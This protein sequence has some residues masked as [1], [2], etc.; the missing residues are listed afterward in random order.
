MM[1]NI[2][3]RRVWIWISL[4]A[5]SGG[6]SLIL[7]ITGV[8][9]KAAESISIVKSSFRA[10]MAVP[11]FRRLSHHNSR[12]QVNRFKLLNSYLGQ[13][14]EAHEATLGNWKIQWWTIAFSHWI[15]NTLKEAI[16]MSSYKEA[17]IQLGPSASHHNKCQLERY[18]YHRDCTNK[19]TYTNCK[20][21]NYSYNIKSKQKRNCLKKQ[22]LNPLY[23]PKI[24]WGTIEIQT[25][26][27]KMHSWAMLKLKSIVW[28][29]WGMSSKKRPLRNARISGPRYAR[30]VKLL[31]QE[32]F[33]GTRATSRKLYR[34]SN[35]KA[36]I[37]KE[38]PT[39]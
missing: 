39:R 10:D 23:T 12:L 35:S 36:Q 7:N 9:P 16:S 34:S 25:S 19:P 31:I 28:K 27:L 21:S 37:V 2:L 13:M 33:K 22:V 8:E 24:K 32:S 17:S 14:G 6:W 11:T 3:G 29:S 30:R 26:S 15:Q 5:P 20:R 38:R 18:K 4:V 1:I